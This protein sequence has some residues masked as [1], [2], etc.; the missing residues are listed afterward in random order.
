MKSRRKLLIVLGAA[1]LTPRWLLGQSKT[2]PILIGW[3]SFSSRESGARALSAL[4]EGLAAL[5][6]QEESQFRI[7]E[8]WAD[9]QDDRLAL[10]T[11]ELAAK[12]LAVIVVSTQRAT[13]QAAKIAP[14]IPIVMV[15]GTDP[16]AAGL[17]KSLARPGG[18][19][20][21]LT[22]MAID[23]AGKHLE[24]LLAAAP[25]VKRVGFL[26]PSKGAVNAELLEVARRSTTHYSVLAH[27]A[28]V[29]RA[30]EIEPAML[31]L[32]KEGAQ[33]LVMLPV[34]LLEAERRGV[35]K[36]A[37]SQRWPVVG[38]SDATTASASSRQ[39]QQ[40]ADCNDRAQ[41]PP[42]KSACA[43][44]LP[45]NGECSTSMPASRCCSSRPRCVVLPA[46]ALLA[47]TVISHTSLTGMC[48]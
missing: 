40:F 45:L 48:N 42:I 16:V 10:V 25:K 6:W 23:L 27:I 2:H 8:R 1:S 9:G 3:L 21:G 30:E 46:I 13:V 44:A 5:G 4:K 31:R 43:G 34:A 33:G 29:S 15:T 41:S 17:V 18:M 20:T 7:E 39:Q 11:Q 36:V 12:N 14:K 24:L 35:M 32:A 22:G 47:V 28:E 19:I 37:L 26:I 38:P